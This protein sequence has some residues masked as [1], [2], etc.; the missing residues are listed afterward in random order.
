[1]PLTLSLQI[2]HSMTRTEGGVLLLCSKWNYLFYRGPWKKNQWPESCLNPLSGTSVASDID[3][4]DHVQR[5][6]PNASRTATKS[7]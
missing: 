4:D 5:H 1:M 2:Q 6:S 3:D 7:A